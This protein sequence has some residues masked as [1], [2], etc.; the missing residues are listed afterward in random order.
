MLQAAIG[1]DAP[2]EVAVIGDA[3]GR[4]AALRSSDGEIV[5]EFD[6]GSGFVA[7]PAVADGCL[8]MATDDGTL[9]CFAAQAGTP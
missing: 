6:A 7:S 8:V 9:W 5:W 1:A 2:A 4:I 3:A